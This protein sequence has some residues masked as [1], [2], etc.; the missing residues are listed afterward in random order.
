MKVAIGTRESF[1]RNPW[2]AWVAA[3][4]IGTH[5]GVALASLGHDHHHGTVESRTW[6]GVQAGARCAPVQTVPGADGD[7][8]CPLCRYLMALQSV[9]PAEAGPSGCPA[10]ALAPIT[11]AKRS[12]TTEV[13]FLGYPARAPPPA[14]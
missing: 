12:C 1:G 8:D 10:F 5:L 6:V 7:S 4:V 9:C 13:C 3:L 14:A 2:G 11:S